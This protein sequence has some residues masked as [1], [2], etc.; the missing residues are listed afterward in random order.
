MTDEDFWLL[1]CVVVAGVVLAVIVT[2][3][4]LRDFV[5]DLL[6]PTSWSS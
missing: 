3:P 5:N 1:F 4:T 6:D 2:S